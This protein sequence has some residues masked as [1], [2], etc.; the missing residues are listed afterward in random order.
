MKTG[1]IRQYIRQWEAC[2]YA[3]GIPEEVPLPLMQQ[4]LAP[5]Y[6]AIA[7]AILKNDA[8]FQSLGFAQEESP[9][10]IELKRIEIAARPT[11]GQK[12]LRLLP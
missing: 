11:S 12:Q 8:N 4:R 6:K 1:R 5:S 2:G 7:F 3:A 9:W 10:Y